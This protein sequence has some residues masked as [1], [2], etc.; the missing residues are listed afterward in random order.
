MQNI[1]KHVLS[2]LLDPRTNP[3]FFLFQKFV[4]VENKYSALGLP[5]NIFSG[6]ARDENK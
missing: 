3:P 2:H 5:E 6:R 4:A 1:E